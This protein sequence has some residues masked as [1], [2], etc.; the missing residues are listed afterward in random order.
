MNRLFSALNKRSPGISSVV[1][2]VDVPV[3]VKEVFV[4]VIVPVFWA[5]IVIVPVLTIS[6]LIV[7]DCAVPNVLIITPGVKLI[8]LNALTLPPAS[9]ATI[10]S[11]LSD[12]LLTLI[13]AP[14]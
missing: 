7:P 5:F 6:V 10:A 11:A 4:D 3:M 8:G 14:E 1:K 12:D 9:K 2:L 13:A